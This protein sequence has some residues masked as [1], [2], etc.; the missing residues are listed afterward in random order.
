MHAGNGKKRELERFWPV[1]AMFFAVDFPRLRIIGAFLRVVK[2]DTALHVWN[3]ILY[4]LQYQSCIDQYVPLAYYPGNANRVK[5]KAA[6][7]LS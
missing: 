5:I 7:D 2:I 1:S 3:S 4:L 6:G